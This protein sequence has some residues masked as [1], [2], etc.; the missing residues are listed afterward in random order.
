[1]IAYVGPGLPHDL[2]AAAAP[3]GWSIDREMPRA[4][5]WMENRFPLWA[6]S[7]LEDWADGAFDQLDA[8]VFSRADD[9]AQRL[10]YYLCELRRVGDLAGPEPLIFDGASAARASSLDWTI[11]GVRKLAARLSL[12]DAA[13]EA[14]IAATNARRHVLPGEAVDQPVCLLTGTAPPDQRLHTVVAR[15]GWH[16]CGPTLDEQWRDTGT[17]VETASGDPCAAIGRQLHGA[18][19]GSRAF[20]DRA[21]A[22]LATARSVSARAVV[23]WLVAEEEAQVWH[24]PAQWCALDAAGLPVLV[25]AGRDWRAD[26]GSADD[27]ARFLEGLA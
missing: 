18:R 8:V 24:V 17:V 4:A 2:L 9:S 3:L 10:Y 26:D 1:M 7:I 20:F 22:L 15:A 21:E 16:A 13:V 14:G 12:D 23:L 11:A 27:I 25:M 5:R 6:H 19:S